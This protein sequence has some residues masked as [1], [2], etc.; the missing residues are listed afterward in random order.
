M[1]KNIQVLFILFVFIQ[2]SPIQGQKRFWISPASVRADFWEMFRPDAKWDTLLSYADVFSIHVNA[3]SG[4]R[5]D[6]THI[7]NAINKFNK[8]S[9]L[10]NFEC[11]GL[12][13]F[14]GCDTLAGERHAQTELSDLN[15]WVSRGGKIDII[16]M[17]SPINTPV[18]GLLKML[19]M[20]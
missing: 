7:K 14:S 12:R 13:P 20:N 9:I 4:N 15:K 2:I 11:G 17:D 8:T 3:L 16:T 1:A 10:I 19:L 5:L 6:T 18:N